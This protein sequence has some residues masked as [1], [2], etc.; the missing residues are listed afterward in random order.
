[1]HALLNWPPI[2]SRNSTELLKALRQLFG[3][4]DSRIGCFLALSYIPVYEFLLWLVNDVGENELAHRVCCCRLAK[5]IYN[6]SEYVVE[7]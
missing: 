4:N 7:A 3:E 1:M 6:L 2:S 5:V